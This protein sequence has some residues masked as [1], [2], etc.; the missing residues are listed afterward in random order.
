MDVCGDFLKRVWTVKSDWTFTMKKNLID[1][2]YKTLNQK[3]KT[4]QIILIFLQGV[5]YI[6]FPIYINIRSQCI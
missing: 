1:N 5:M 2:H 4:N 6:F 3:L